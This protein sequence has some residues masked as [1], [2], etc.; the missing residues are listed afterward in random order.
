MAQTI[1]HM[2]HRN[3]KILADDLNTGIKLTG[4]NENPCIQCIQGKHHR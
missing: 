2:N 1:G 4:T 3:M